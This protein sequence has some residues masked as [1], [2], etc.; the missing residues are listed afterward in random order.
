MPRAPVT[1]ERLKERFDAGKPK[2]L[3]SAIRKGCDWA[4]GMR[5]DRSCAP[6]PRAFVTSADKER[7]FLAKM[8]VCAP[9]DRANPSDAE[10]QRIIDAALACVGVRPSKEFRGCVVDNYDRVRGPTVAPL[11]AP[12]PPPPPPPRVP[13]M[14]RPFE[15]VTDEAAAD[16]LFAV[17]QLL[18]LRYPFSKQPEK[19]AFDETRRRQAREMV[20]SIDPGLLP[21]LEARYRKLD[22]CERM[23]LPR[24]VANVEMDMLRAD[25]SFGDPLNA[26]SKRLVEEYAREEI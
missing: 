12:E 6:G 20:S 17:R 26:V 11:V 3:N 25:A 13:V 23:L 14:V 9:S 2:A 15:G 18:S 22:R 19:Q 1:C 8:G 24:K 4:V 21:Y 5:G 10:R 7:A 16:A